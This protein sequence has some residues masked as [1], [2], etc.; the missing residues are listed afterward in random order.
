MG[1]VFA[2]GALLLIADD[3]LLLAPDGGKSHLND[4]KQIGTNPFFSLKP[5]QGNGLSA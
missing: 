2:A 1:H 4:S 3:R 5:E